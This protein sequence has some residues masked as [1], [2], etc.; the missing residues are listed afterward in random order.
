[1]PLSRLQF[2]PGINREVTSFANEGG[3]VDGDKVRFRAGFRKP[4]AAGLSSTRRG[5]WARR[6]RFTHGSR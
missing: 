6:G 1:M 2:R 5:S 3:W 4:S